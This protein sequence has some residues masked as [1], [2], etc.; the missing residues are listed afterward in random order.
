MIQAQEILGKSH[1][2]LACQMQWEAV[3][4]QKLVVKALAIAMA[5]PRKTIRP[6]Q[7]IGLADQQNSLVGIFQAGG[8]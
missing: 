8:R 5:V 2:V 4:N 3:Q 1:L 7:V 6:K